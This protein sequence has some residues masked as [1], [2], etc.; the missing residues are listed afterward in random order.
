MNVSKVDLLNKKF[1]KKLFG[2]SC[3]EVDQLMLELAEV[4]GQAAEDK[5]DLLRKVKDLEVSV[6]EYRQRDE[7]LRDTLMSTQR[8]VDD[9]KGSAEKE[10]RLIIDEAK[11]KAEA[12]VQQGYY[13][14]AQVHEDLENLKRQRAHYE[15]QL[16]GILET[17]MRFLDSRD[18]DIEK[19]EKMEAKVKFLKKAE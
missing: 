3:A 11:V 16:R 10:A 9:I 6:K 18:P 17:H 4:L 8:M 7:T 14:L 12:T 15:L 5:R 13:R 2:Y 1:T 19:L